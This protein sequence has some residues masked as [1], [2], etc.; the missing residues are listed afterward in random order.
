M[1]T[2]RTA[3]KR[4][5]TD[6]GRGSADSLG[7]LGRDVPGND[8]KLYRCDHWQ[9]RTER[10]GRTFSERCQF[11][12]GQRGRTNDSGTSRSVSAGAFSR[13]RRRRRV[14]QN[15]MGDA[16]KTVA[17]SDKP[18]QVYPD[19]IVHRRRTETN[20]LVIE[21]KKTSNP[22]TKDKD[23]LKLAAYRRDLGYLHALFLRLGVGDTVGT[24]PE[25]QWV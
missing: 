9:G 2:K 13:A 10:V 25:C 18:E 23:L 5:E 15:R 12:S 11:A 17:W 16:P 1:L 20:I 7:A 22:E 3:N 19:I 6:A 21:L 14:Q 8:R 24:V 4:L